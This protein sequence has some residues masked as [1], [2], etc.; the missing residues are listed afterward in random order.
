LTASQPS[1]F[2]VLKNHLRQY[3]PDDAARI[4]DVPAAAIRR[5]AREFGEAAAIGSTTVIEGQEMPLRPVCA[6]PD[7]RGLAAHMYGVWTGT[8]VQLL[9]VMVGAVDVPGGNLSTNV[10][11]PHGKFPRR[12]GPEGSSLRVPSWAIAAPTRRVRRRR[13]AHSI[14]VISCRW[15]EARGRSWRWG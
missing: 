7:C 2:Q 10:V 4:T 15:E 13:R 11:G 8:A 12:R 9:N 5:L 3:S 1:A 14:W 6:F